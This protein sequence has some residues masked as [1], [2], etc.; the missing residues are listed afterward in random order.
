MRIRASLVL[1]VA[2]L[3]ACGRSIDTSVESDPIDA[4]TDGSTA[5]DGSTTDATTADSARG[6]DD[7]DGAIADAGH[8]GSAVADSD[9]TIPKT[10]SK[11]QDAFTKPWVYSDSGWKQP[12][13]A[14]P[15]FVYSEAPPSP[16]A[17]LQAGSTGSP[18][19]SFLAHDVL[20]NCRAHLRFNFTL[21]SGADNL[22]DVTIAR[23]E[24]DFIPF[25]LV[26]ISTGALMASY[27]GVKTTLSQVNSTVWYT[28]EFDFPETVPA[29][30]TNLSISLNGTI[31][32]GVKLTKGDTRFTQIQLGALTVE[33]TSAISVTVGIDDV[34]YN[35]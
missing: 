7:D 6:D 3:A 22:G 29:N 5:I 8:D 2:I 9:A 31:I 12:L 24:S 28:V 1:G 33:S 25:E 20:P 30:G 35:P 18:L 21:S 15:Y 27:G 13:Q 10:C 17:D 19:S 16:H 26:R 11:F 14:A 34:V 4:G 32:N 23:L